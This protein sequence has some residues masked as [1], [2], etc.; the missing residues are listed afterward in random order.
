M[1]SLAAAASVTHVSLAD[2]PLYSDGNA[3]KTTTKKRERVLA[4]Q[5]AAA[6][7]ATGSVTSQGVAAHAVDKARATLQGHRHRR[8]G[9]RALRR[10]RLAGGRR[11]VR[12]PAGRRRRAARPGRARRRGHRDARDRPRPRAERA[13]SASRRRS[14]ARTSFAEN[15]RALRAAGCDIIVDD[16]VYFDES[17]FQDGPI[18]AGGQRRHRRRRALLQLGRQRGQRRRPHLRQLRG[19]LRRLRPDDR[20]V[21]RRGARLRSGPGVQVL[22]PVSDDSRRRADDPAVGRPAGPLRR[23]LRPVR[24][25]RR[26]QRRSAFSKTSRTATTT[27]SRAS[28]C[29]SARAGLARS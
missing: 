3:V 25:R 15:I 16:V 20:Q 1:K 18:G 6:V 11:G 8:E 26:R 19:R 12:R 22:D 28:T 23:R 29:R 10:R 24:R 21:R 7:P 14:P 13:R 17:P 5:V 27:R 2:T 4:A 9:L